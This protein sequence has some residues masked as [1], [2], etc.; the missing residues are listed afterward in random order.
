MVDHAITIANNLVVVGYNPVQ[1]W[2]ALTWGTNGWRFDGDILNDVDKPIDFGSTTLS[3]TVTK[4]IEHPVDLGSTLL[5]DSI[6]KAFSRSI[7][8]GSTVMGY[9]ISN[10][11][12]TDKN[13]YNYVFIG[14]VIDADKRGDAT[15]AAATSQASTWIPVAGASA[16]WS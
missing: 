16:V 6:S 14:G 2:G 12:L 10:A 1:A 9:E 8:F 5:S 11:Y 4:D 13:G 7:S 3:E 15:W